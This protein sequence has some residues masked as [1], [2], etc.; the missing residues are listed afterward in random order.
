[1]SAIPARNAPREHP[2]L[3]P[4]IRVVV[5]GNSTAI[6]IGPIRQSRY[7]G[8]FPE[9][10]ER[11]LR[12]NGYDALVQN[13]SRAW[14]RVDKALPGFLDPL[15]QLCPDVVVINYG[16]AECQ[17]RLV[18]ARLMWWLARRK[19]APPLGRVTSVI[20]KVFDAPMRRLIAR[21]LRNVTPRLKMRTNRVRPSRF[22][23]ELEQLIRVS[24]AKTAG[25]V[26]VTTVSPASPFIER[27]WSHLNERCSRYSALIMEVV[28]ALDDPCIQIVDMKSIHDALGPK[29]AM[30]DGLHWTAKGHEAI[31]QAMFDS[32][33]AWVESGGLPAAAAARAEAGL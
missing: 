9:Q 11:V 8:T 10:L 31:A 33:Q 19:Q 25:L 24:R 6:N 1:M 4:R 21:I 20:A 28:A 14:N 16:G 26:L 18:P 5:Q 23:R 22:T 12:E 17:P 2:P 13:R 7:E 29:V 30:Y 3:P 15:A 32:I 27:L